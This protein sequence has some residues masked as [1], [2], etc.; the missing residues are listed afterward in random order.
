MRLSGILTL[1]LAFA[2]QIVFAQEKTVTGTVT[3]PQGMPLPGVNVIVDNTSRGT[4][5]DFDG[6]YSISAQA[7]EILVFSYLGFTNARYTVGNISR[8]DVTLS[9][10]A[11]E[12]AEV[13]VVA[14]GTQTKRSIVGSVV[15]L[16]E[17]TLEQQQL[18]SIT[19]AIQGNVPGVN[20]LQSGG[21]PGE[22]PTIRIRGVGSIN[23][24][25]EPLIIVDGAPFN[26]NINSISADQISSMNVL[27]DASSTA[28]YGSRGANGVIVI[29]TKR[30]GFNAEPKLQVTAVGGISTPAVELHD[31]LGTNQYMR[32]AWE[33]ARNAN[34]ENGQDAVTAGQNAATNLIPNL[35]YN[36]YDVSQPV[37]AQGNLVDGANLL[38]ETN[39]QDEMLRDAAIRQEYGVNYSGGGETT[40]YFLSAN[41][42]E[43]EGSVKESNFERITTRLN[44]EADVKDWLT[45]GL[46]S[47]FSTSKQ[48]FP[49]QSGNSY[50]SSI[51]WINSLS[52]V[53]P[54]YERDADGALAL[55][56]FG[57]PVYDYGTGEGLINATRPLFSNE[58]A[59]GS[60][61]NYKNLNKRTSITANGFAE[62]SFTDDLSFKTNLSYEEFMHDYYLYAH[63]EF[64]YAADADGRITQ[65]RDITKTLNL[66]NS[67][68]YSK[69]FGDHTVNADLIHEAYKFEFDHVGA[70]GEGFLPNVYALSG[71]TSPVAAEGYINEERLVGYLG[72]LSYNFQD[73]YFIEGSYRRDGSS[74]FTADT[75]WGDFFS[76]GGSWV[77]SDELFLKNNTVLNYLKL[78]GSYGE[79]GNNNILDEDNFQSYFP[80]I[81][82]FETGWNQGS[83]TGV[84]LGGVTDPLLT[85]ET[86]AMANVGLDFTFL[87]NRIEGSAEYYNKESVD[88]IYAQ[89]LPLS[90]GNATITTN[91]GSVRNYGWEFMVRTR[92][93]ITNDF[94]WSTNFNFSIDNNEI[95]ELTQDSYIEGTKRW[96][97]GRSLYEFYIRE[98]AGVDPEDGYGMWYKDEVDAN[99][100]PTGERVLTKDYAEADRYYVGESL[101][102]LVG[103]FT[104]DFR[105][106]NFDLNALFNFSFGAQIYDYSY[107]GL[108]SGFTDPG[109]QQ[110]PDLAAR[111]QEPGD[112]TD[113]PLLL[114]AQNDFSSTSTRFLFDN[115]YVRLK[116]V[117]LGYNLPQNTLENLDM[118]R[119]RIYLRG[120]NLWTWHSHFG[121]DPEQSIAG[122]TNSRSYILKTV[123]LGLNIEL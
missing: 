85:W 90:T 26:G 56:N 12:L 19:G 23:A 18:T 98:W 52:S 110:S 22:N 106:K 24:S 105:Y 96:E 63:N 32:Y 20:I 4:Q 8:I 92:N 34:L 115:D 60:L 111:W 28:L 70:Q 11:A 66:I 2:V 101:P 54:L 118:S 65:D 10:D 89:P 7:G 5:T 38:W 50:Q 93:I 21:Q 120:D 47:S 35:G 6:N 58:N 43:Q 29:T 84:L 121:I 55:D 67:L 14:Y 91:V 51:Q 42:L 123:S 94:T 31:L 104:T 109:Y 112:I 1:L 113:V 99:G 114:Q 17:E 80:Y 82:A 61:Y 25:A 102:D 59:V 119:F 86:T 73:R 81:Q 48:N 30:G 15:S 40:R 69:T 45:V 62:I 88:L 87:N 77:I 33:A 39:W 116:S 78:R 76:V 95:T 27:K 117:T 37:D 103:G 44:L 13:V 79:L 53:Y 97:E 16:G 72:R 36:P 100:E 41:Y 9:E 68:N 108:M 64:G 74:R 49:E 83:N 46:N 107:A 57:N 71:S 122:T 75:R 3:D